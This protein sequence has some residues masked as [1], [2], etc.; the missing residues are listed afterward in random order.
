[1]E[2]NLTNFISVFPNNFI[3]LMH[4]FNSDE[5]AGW[6]AIFSSSIKIWEITLNNQ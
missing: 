2:N 4:S 6:F 1:M 5:V 3:S